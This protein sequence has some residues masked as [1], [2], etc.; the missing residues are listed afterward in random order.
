MEENFHGVSVLRFSSDSFFQRGSGEVERG[1]T[2]QSGASGFE[3]WLLLLFS[4]LVR[5]LDSLSLRVFIG[6]VE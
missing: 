4:K 5:S 3:S 1:Q 6:K 2:L